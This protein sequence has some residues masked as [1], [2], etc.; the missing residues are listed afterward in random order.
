MAD[1]KAPAKEAPAGAEI[2]Q[3]D[4]NAPRATIVNQDVK[5]LSFEN[6]NAHE[7]FKAF[8]GATPKM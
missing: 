5:D 7:V 6:P 2:P 4:P 3:G 8:A 1:K